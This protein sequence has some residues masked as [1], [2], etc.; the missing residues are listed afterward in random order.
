MKTDHSPK[1]T[2]RN[3]DSNSELTINVVLNSEDNMTNNASS[4]HN[5]NR[6]SNRK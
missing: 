5:P 3:V 4:M 2:N 6:T 1:R